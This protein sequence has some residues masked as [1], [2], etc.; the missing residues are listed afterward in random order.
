MWLPWGGGNRSPKDQVV[1]EI[2]KGGMGEAATAGSQSQEQ[3]LQCLC[4]NITDACNL[5][6]SSEA[7]RFAGKST[8][9]GVR[10]TGVQLAAIAPACCVTLGKQLSK[11]LDLIFPH[12]E[13]RDITQSST[14]AVKTRDDKQPI[15]GQLLAHNSHTI[16]CQ[17]YVTNFTFYLFFNLPTKTK[18]AGILCYLLQKNPL[19]CNQVT[20][21]T[22]QKRSHFCV[23]ID[24]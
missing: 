12:L 19:L 7:S 4:D 11:S 8:S 15:L 20:G 23:L 3:V 22:S 24:Y 13:N 14:S 18:I 9:F 21:K 17:F 2:E 5:R 10:H 16:K 6:F 1:G